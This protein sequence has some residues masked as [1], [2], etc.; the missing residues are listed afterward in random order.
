MLQHQSYHQGAHPQQHYNQ[1]NYQRQ[2][3]NQASS[4]LQ[5]L[6]S[7]LKEYISRS[8]A[9]IQSQTNSLRALEDQVGHLS[10]APSNRKH[11]TLL[12]DTEVPKAHGKTSCNGHRK[13][14]TTRSGRKPALE[15]KQQDDKKS[16]EKEMDKEV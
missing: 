9:M 1:Q 10:N 6:E 5:S 11:G 7:S 2:S 14:I 4:I 13:V 3:S 12:N 16:V 8:E 15:S